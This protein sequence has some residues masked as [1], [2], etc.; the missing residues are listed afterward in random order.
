MTWMSLLFLFDISTFEVR[1]RRAD[2]ARSSGFA[3]GRHA[4]RP[5]DVAKKSGRILSNC[6]SVIGVEEWHFVSNAVIGGYIGSQDRMSHAHP[7]PP[8]AHTNPKRLGN[9]PRI[10]WQF[11]ELS[12]S[13]Q[14]HSFDWWV[15]G[16]LSAA[17]RLI[18]MAL[19]RRYRKGMQFSWRK[20]HLDDPEFLVHAVSFKHRLGFKTHDLTLKYLL[21]WPQVCRAASPF[22]PSQ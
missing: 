3:F 13:R 18:W 11:Y 4:I 14:V 1:K 21:S 17:N 6:W 7:L 2:L 9:A 12:V 19:S 20:R 10:Q 15:V 16:F 22:F 8:L 5:W